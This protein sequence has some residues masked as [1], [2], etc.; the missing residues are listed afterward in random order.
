[1]NL[2]SLA[3]LDTHR[4]EL[5][6]SHEEFPMSL[7]SVKIWIVGIAL[8]E[9]CPGT[10]GAYY[11]LCRCWYSIRRSHVSGI[12]DKE[13]KHAVVLAVDW[14]RLYSGLYGQNI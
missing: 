5:W 12:H 4:S 13:R 11:I 7:S 3:L 9:S 14:M 2:A 10:S 8:I 1:M 6:G